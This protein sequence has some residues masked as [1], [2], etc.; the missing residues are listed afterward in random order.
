MHPSIDQEG[1]PITQFLQFVSENS[2]NKLYNVDM[3]KPKATPINSLVAANIAQLTDKY[4]AKLKIESINIDKKN[5][6]LR[7]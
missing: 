4:P 7:P 1:N 2:D 5:G 3:K 6:I